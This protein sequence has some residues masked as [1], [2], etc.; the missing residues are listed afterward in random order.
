MPN[1]ASHS[2]PGT[3]TSIFNTLYLVFFTIHIPLMLLVD[4]YPLY[5]THLIPEFMTGVRKWYIA[6]Y[7]GK[8]LAIESVNVL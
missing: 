4:F 8:Y 7:K 2:S 6:T 1:M 5:P 3:M